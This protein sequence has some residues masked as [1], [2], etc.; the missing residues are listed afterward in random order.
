MNRNKEEIRSRADVARAAMV[1]VEIAKLLRLSRS[2]LERMYMEDVSDRINHGDHPGLMPYADG[3]RDAY[4][5]AIIKDH[6]EFVYFNGGERISLA[7]ARRKGPG[8][9]GSAVCG[10]QWL[11]SE[12][13]FTTFQK[14]VD[15]W[16]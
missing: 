11:D 2:E 5:T 15:L 8:E 4:V 14:E 6:C 3:M 7:E 13:D 1:V 16:I 10:Y 12:S 9:L